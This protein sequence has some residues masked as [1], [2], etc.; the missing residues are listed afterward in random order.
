MNIS[1]KTTTH[2]KILTLI[3]I[4]INGKKVHFLL[5]DFGKQ[6]PVQCS[7]ALS[8]SPKSLSHEERHGKQWFLGARTSK[9]PVII[10]KWSCGLKTRINKSQNEEQW[11]VFI[12][13]L[14]VCP[15]IPSSARHSCQWT[16]THIYA[17]WQSFIGLFYLKDLNYPETPQGENSKHQKLWKRVLFLWIWQTTENLRCF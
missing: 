3:V 5:T 8:K 12:I 9:C 17:F 7:R 1:T 10:L 4:I 6:G 14:G 11:F 16:I 13:I 15:S 2:H